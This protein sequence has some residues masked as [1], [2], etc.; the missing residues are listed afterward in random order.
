MDLYRYPE[1]NSNISKD[2][3][4][5]ILERVDNL[6]RQAMSGTDNESLYDE[7]AKEVEQV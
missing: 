4:D 5:A 2:K 3:F 1:F 7:I 6:L